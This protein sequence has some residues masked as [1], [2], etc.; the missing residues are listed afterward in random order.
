M[1]MRK[2]KLIRNTSLLLILLGIGVSGCVDLKPRADGTRYFVLGSSASI[3]ME[4][5]SEGGLS[6][7]IQSFDIA[8]YLDSPRIATRIEGVEITYSANA[9]WGE[10]LD[11]AIQKRLV[12]ELGASS[13]IGDVH[14]LPWPPGTTPYRRLGI[15]VN[16]FEGRSDSTVAVGLSWTVYDRDGMML[17]E[18]RVAEQVPGWL[19]G[20]YRNLV[21]KLDEALSSASA[22]VAVSIESTR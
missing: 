20:D 3:V 11:D 7:G 9:R 2:V 22:A 12:A 15:S 21:I 13:G 10:Q 19:P 1:I 18:G 4:P 16:N 5:S 17:D 6:V 8:P 14:G